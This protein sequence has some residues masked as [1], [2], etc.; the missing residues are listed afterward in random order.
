MCEQVAE[1]QLAIYPGAPS[2]SQGLL[3]GCASTSS[4]PAHR[5]WSL[6]QQHSHKGLSYSSSRL[7]SGTTEALPFC[8]GYSAPS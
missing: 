2:H 3:R 1:L 5:A 7:G 8:H 4:E 6:F